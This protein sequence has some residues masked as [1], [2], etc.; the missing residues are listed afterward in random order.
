MHSNGIR[1]VLDAV[2]NHVGRE[3][4]A[5][6]D[7]KNLRETAPGAR[8]FRSIN[9]KGNNSYNDGFSY[10]CWNGCQD[11]IELNLA[12]PEVSSYLLNCVK[13]WVEEFDIDGLR[14]DAA[15]C[16]DIHFLQALKERTAA[17]KN[18]FWLM[19]E[20]LHSN[21][22][23]SVI[24]RDTL[25][26]VTNYEVYKGL[27]SSHNDRN[28][29]E[30]AYSLNRLFGESGLLRE[31]LLYNFVDNHDVERVISVLKNKEHL[32]P[33]YILLFSIPGIP[34][35]YYGSEWGISGR[36]SE[37][38]KALRPCL[39][40]R[41]F[42]NTGLSEHITRLA[43]VRKKLET[44]KT[45]DFRQLYVSG[46]AFAF[47]RRRGND[48]AVVAVNS[49]EKEVVVDL[50][51]NGTGGAELYDVLDNDKKYILSNGALHVT[52]KKCSGGIF[53]N[54]RII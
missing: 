2:F 37:G 41:Q 51:I 46:E 34:S 47:I 23:G 42:K 35:I 5:F 19:G 8:W 15:D 39:D 10:R 14:L 40:I 1:V 33:A 48:M 9:F 11:L 27:Y 22:Y 30:L 13:T 32:Y 49:G 31:N 24:G 16:L 45:G 52:L 6:K 25:D 43:A 44:L 29:F 17:L 12:N 21:R 53:T 38:D 36:K 26:S 7:V 28:Y 20:V 50:K 18:D 54:R 3:F 4:L